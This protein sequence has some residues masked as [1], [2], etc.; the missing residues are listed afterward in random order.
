[1][2]NPPPKA[3]LFTLLKLLFPRWQRR[4]VNGRSMHPTLPQGTT[5]L[6][7]TAAYQHSAPKV[8]D[9]VL[10]Q[11]PYEPKNKMIKRVTAASADGRYHL[12]GD[13]PESTSSTDS[14]G[15]GDFS[16]SQILAKVTHKF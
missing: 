4:R 8:G 11:H 15:L 2:F 12:R 7:D 14:R 9:V 3:S 16:Q 6:L 10:V 13:N 5:V 1:M